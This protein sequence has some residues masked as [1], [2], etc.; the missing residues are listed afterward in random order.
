MYAGTWPELLP[1]LFQCIQSQEGRLQEAA[2]IIFAQLAIQEADVLA[3]YMSTLHPV[4]ASSF[5]SENKDVRAAGLRATA[6]FVE[7]LE[8]PGNR[9]YIHYIHYTPYISERSLAHT[10]IH[11]RTGSH[12]AVFCCKDLR[13]ALTYGKRDKE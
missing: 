3:P 4:L 12:V 1:F 13:I 2:L 7:G 11:T 9:T 8:E 5:R 10:N 6:S